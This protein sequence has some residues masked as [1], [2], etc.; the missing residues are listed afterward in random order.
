MMFKEHPECKEWMKD[1]L[2][3]NNVEHTVQTSMKQTSRGL[4]SLVLFTDQS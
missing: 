1:G 4:Q 3:D 2:N